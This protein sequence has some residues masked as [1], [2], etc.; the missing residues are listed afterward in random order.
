MQEKPRDLASLSTGIFGIG[1]YISWKHKI[2][3]I[4]G[5]CSGDNWQLIIY[6]KKQQLIACC[7]LNE[8][9]YQNY[10]NQTVKRFY[11]I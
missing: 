2:L 3:L 7:C 8:T 5:P 4:K 10:I 9:F 11:P 6:I 1:V